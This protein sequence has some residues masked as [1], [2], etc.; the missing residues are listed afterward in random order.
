MGT[1]YHTNIKYK[2][3]CGS[4][5]IRKLILRQSIIRHK[6]MHFI[7]ISEDIEEIIQS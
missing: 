4:I 2:K 6:E 5:N 3:G 7:V 1:I